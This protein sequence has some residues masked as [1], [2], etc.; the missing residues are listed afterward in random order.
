M[1]TIVGM[2]MKERASRQNHQPLPAHLHLS[3]LLTLRF[4]S[5]Y[6]E[7][8]SWALPVFRSPDHP[9]TRSPDSPLP[10]RPKSCERKQPL[11]H[12][13]PVDSFEVKACSG[14]YQSATDPLHP[15]PNEINVPS[16]VA[17][18]AAFFVKKSVA[19]CSGCNTCVASSATRSR[20]I[21]MRLVA[22]AT[23]KWPFF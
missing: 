22:R 1:Y 16:G 9:I 2:R 3:A 5:G 18:R 17:E 10:P 4:M 13:L 14:S 8:G 12:P 11:S 21:N 23:E 7:I 19:S 6:M 20:P 15:N